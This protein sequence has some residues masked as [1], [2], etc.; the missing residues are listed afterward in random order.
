MGNVLQTTVD[1][2]IWAAVK[3]LPSRK[4]R[5]T[6][7]Y[8]LRR[9]FT[10]AKET[11]WGVINRDS[12]MAF[13][14]YLLNSNLAMATIQIHL[15]ALRRMAKVALESGQISESTARPILSVPGVRRSGAK[16]GKWLSLEQAIALLNA[17]NIE[18]LV[19]LRDFTVLALL[20]GAGMRRAEVASLTLGH[21]RE[22]D[23]H[24][25][26]ADY[27]GKGQKLSCSPLPLG[28]LSDTVRAYI[29]RMEGLGMTVDSPLIPQI[30]VSGKPMGA[31]TDQSIRLIVRKYAEPMGLEIGV[32]APHDLR[33]TFAGLAD[34][35]GISIQEISCALRHSS[36]TTTQRYLAPIQALA[37]P[38]ASRVGL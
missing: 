12:V 4:S 30:H 37:N 36:V 2:V 17:P 11:G 18:T 29:R 6:E 8:A 14:E 22:I 35:A 5:E 7:A 15:S 21:M 27:R 31:I 34:K 23:G 13:R 3:D 24:L 26:A 16:T 9:Y 32:V 20:V 10:W 25:C 1:S 19:G 33:R 28:R 38:V